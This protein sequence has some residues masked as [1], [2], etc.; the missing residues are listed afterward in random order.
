MTLKRE[1]EYLR[2]AF[3]CLN[4]EYWDVP[5]EAFLDDGI[6]DHGEALQ[7]IESIEGYNVGDQAMFL[8]NL[9]KIRQSCKTRLLE[10]TKTN[11]EEAVVWAAVGLLYTDE[12][13]LG[14]GILK[15]K[16]I[17][18]IKDYQLEKG[19]WPLHFLLSEL[20]EAPKVAEGLLDEILQRAKSNIDD[21]WESFTTVELMY[22]NSINADTKK[23]H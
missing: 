14:L 10:L 1:I 12:P 4:V 11:D 21:R 7:F 9:V 22:N 15:E 19:K 3:E 2:E 20:A 18:R 8:A 16:C 6:P 23:H 17:E 5:Y 13:D